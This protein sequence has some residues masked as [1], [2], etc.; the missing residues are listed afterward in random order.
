MAS[1]PPPYA[2][3]GPALV[4]FT[5]NFTITNLRHTDNMWPGSAKFNFIESVVQRLLR[6]LFTNSS[7]GSL[8]TGCRLTTLRP[9]KGGAATGV[10]TICTHHPDPAGLML[11]RERLY[12]ELS[13]QTHS[14]TWL[15]PYILDRD[16]LYVNGYTRPALTSISSVF[17]TSTPSL[18]TSAASVSFS[19]STVTGPALVPF[20][21]NFTIINL[22]YMNDMQPLGS[23][24]FNKIEKI[25]QHLLEPL[26]R[27]TSVS[28]LYSSCRLTSLSTSQIATQNGHYPGGFWSLVPV[29]DLPILPSNIK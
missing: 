20:T 13:Q 23:M 11:D 6:P 12:W 21:L 5:V 15:G 4:P 25:L 19:S 3:G 10:D 7:I 26:F 28:S 27:N 8:Y 2:A 9:E 1:P 22:H 18:G 17:V 29:L 16:R 14:V 24:K